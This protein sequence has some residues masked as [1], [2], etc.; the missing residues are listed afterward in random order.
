MNSDRTRLAVAALD[1]L[2][3][4]A[5]RIGVKFEPLV[6]IYVPPLLR[7]STRT[8][9]VFVARSQSTTALI[10]GY[11]QIPSIIP[12]ILSAC[13]E[14]KM[15]SGRLAAAEAALRTLNK[16]DWTQKDTK[17]KVGSIEEL[18]K[19]TGRDKDSAV[20]QTSKAIFAAYKALFP[21]RIDE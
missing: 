9:K 13:K 2:G 10:I 1:C 3:A 15:A 8:N 5:P 20:R 19:I 16:W 4:I 6:T 7:L 17:V 21:E 12:Y 11:C 14:S 18:L